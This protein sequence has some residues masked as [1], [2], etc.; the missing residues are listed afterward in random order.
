MVRGALECVEPV[1]PAVPLDPDDEH[2]V[3]VTSA[4]DTE[5]ASRRIE[6]GVCQ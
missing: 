3:A 5:T 1:E 2:A 4:T 6:R